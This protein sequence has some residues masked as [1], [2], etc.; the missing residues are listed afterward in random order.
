MMESRTVI[1]FGDF[2]EKERLLYFSEESL[3]CSPIQFPEDFLSFNNEHVKISTSDIDTQS[4][5]EDDKDTDFT[6]EVDYSCYEE[7][8]ANVVANDVSNQVD[9][10]SSSDGNV[11]EAADTN[12]PESN[13]SQTGDKYD[14]Q[15]VEHE[16]S[17]LPASSFGTNS[18]EEEVSLPNEPNLNQEF[19]S[20][21]ATEPK[22][23][24][25]SVS[26]VESP[27]NL[28]VDS[29]EV[30]QTN[31]VTVGTKTMMTT[32]TRT[33]ESKND[34][35]KS[36]W[37]DLF[38]PK[39]SCKQQGPLASPSPKSSP[40]KSE[41]EMLSNNVISQK[42]Q[43]RH[44]FTD[45]LK[46]VELTNQIPQLQPRGLKNNGNWCYINSTLQVL[47]FCPSFYHFLM[48]FRLKTSRG[49]SSTP[50][51]DALVLFA[52]QFS[53]LPS[54][55]SGTKSQEGSK[56]EVVMGMP[57]EPTYVYALLS[58]VK[59]SLSHQGKQ[60]DAEE[61]L[62]CILN[63]LHEE[64]T[65]LA[66]TEEKQEPGAPNK[67][68]GTDSEPGVREGSMGEWEQVGPRNKSTV[69]RKST[70]QKSPVAEIFG[71]YLRSS[72]LQQGIKE[73]ASIQPFFSIQLDLRGEVSTVQQA[74]DNFFRVEEVEGFQCDKRKMEVEV[75]KKWTL[76]S[77]PVVM[78]LHLKR[79]VVNKNG[80][81]KLTKKISYDP[82][83]NIPQ[84][85]ISKGLRVRNKN[86]LMY[87]LFAVTY[88]HGKNL[89][90][91]HYTSDIFH[92]AVGWLRAD[93]DKVRTIP[94]KF[95]FNPLQSRDPYL[96]YYRRGDI[97]T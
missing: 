56:Q 18:T 72:L 91:G 34:T 96:L 22:E 97:S 42:D 83:L 64:L 92:P 79:F 9:N 62:S 59:T 39:S 47:M 73:S 36:L 90:G 37:T 33:V 5:A 2:S 69:T 54:R 68:S 28:A 12:L 7:R 27:A 95:V 50:I 81:E 65:Q 63:G 14:V 58:Q 53:L 77:L 25:A 10:T 19:N 67:H 38:K 57:F 48:K 4:Q 88:H 78:I 15:E 6:Q 40:K 16:V 32:S 49:T 45:V 75:S 8:S 70:M 44:Y 87:K 24:Q 71:G 85:T 82:E 17:D 60:E 94:T 26:E 51:L 74:F 29:N 41:D 31:V 52:S 43:F 61:F 46:K 23:C 66:S 30:N 86:Q 84:D 89:Y 76:D 3:K 35:V 93:D 55:Q 13:T 1:S 20:T 21:E 80:C 11:E